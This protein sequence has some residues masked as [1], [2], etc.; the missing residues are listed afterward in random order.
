MLL[1]VCLEMYFKTRRVAKV[2]LARKKKE[3]RS[4]AILAWARVLPTCDLTIGPANPRMLRARQTGT[5]CEATRPPQLQMLQ[6]GNRA[7]KRIHV[8]A[9]SGASSVPPPWDSN[10]ASLLADLALG[11]KAIPSRLVC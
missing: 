10:Q 11:A 6:H 7:E 4:F 1:W 2:L 8:K 5:V 9:A 3:M